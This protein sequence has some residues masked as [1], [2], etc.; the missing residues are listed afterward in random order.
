MAKRIPVIALVAL[1]ALVSY[2]SMATRRGNGDI[3]AYIGEIMR[4]DRACTTDEDFAAFHRDVRLAAKPYCTAEQ[5]QD[6]TA[7]NP[8][9]VASSSPDTGPKLLQKYWGRRKRGPRVIYRW[10][11]YALWRCGIPLGMV[12]YVVSGICAGFC[13]W[14]IHVIVGGG[15]RG[16]ATAA[17]CA[18]GWRLD[19]VGHTA[20]PDSMAALVALLV[21]AY[22]RRPWCAVLIP[23]S[24]LVRP[25]MVIF[26]GLAVWLIPIPWQW[27]LATLAVTASLYVGLG[28]YYNCPPWS[29][30]FYRDIVAPMFQLPKVPVD[31]ATP[32]VPFD[33]YALVMKHRYVLLYR[34]MWS[35]MFGIVAA[36]A[37]LRVTR[38]SWPLLVLPVAYYLLHFAAFPFSFHRFFFWCYVSVT[39]CLITDRPAS[40]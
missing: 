21:L 27:K 22:Y 23:I 17:V 18:V 8:G 5:W 9:R 2:Y 30:W 20:S 3:F 19:M 1:M 31:R 36:L 13:L 14:P 7:A 4:M 26:A 11:C 15:W 28:H 12:C 6:L 24:V 33:V 35:H 32:G 40:S 37:F 38:T 16:V 39:L 34:S 29:E 25:D 10:L